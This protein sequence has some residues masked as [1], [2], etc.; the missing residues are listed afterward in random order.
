MINIPLGTQILG[1]GIDSL[2][3]ERVKPFISFDKKQLNKIF[4][5]QELNY[6]L[7]I[8]EKRAERFSGYFA[9]KEAAYKAISSII[10]EQASFLFFCKNIEIVKNQYNAPTL[11]FNW[12][13]IKS[14]SPNASFRFF[15]SMTHTKYTATAIVICVN[16]YND[17]QYF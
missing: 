11:K 15:V 9:I 4:S 13:A 1:V 6:C 12:G 14:R 10:Q 7:S 2:E 3:I 5:D 17:S 8:K 16:T